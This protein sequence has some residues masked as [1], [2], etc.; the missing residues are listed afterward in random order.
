M[1]RLSLRAILCKKIYAMDK[2]CMC[3]IKFSFKRLQKLFSAIGTAFFAGLLI[4]A[5]F[6]TS[7]VAETASKSGSIIY[8]N[9]AVSGGAGDGGSWADAYGS[10]QDALGVATSGDEI[11]VAAGVYY[12]DDGVAQT[13]ND[14][15][16]TFQ[17][18]DGIKVYGGFDATE[19]LLSERDWE[20]NLTVLSGDIDQNDTTNGYGLVTDPDS[21]SGTNSMHVVNTSNVTNTTTIDGFAI[22]AGSA[23]R[24]SGPT[25]VNQG[26]GL[27]SDDGHPQLA[28]MLFVGNQ[29]WEQGGAAYVSGS[30]SSW[31]D[32][33]LTNVSFIN[34]RVKAD[35]VDEGEVRAPQNTEYDG[36]AIYVYGTNLT[37]IDVDFLFNKVNGETQHADY[38]NSGAMHFRSGRLTMHGARVI[39]NQAEANYGGV[40]IRIYNNENFADI[41]N[42]VFAG[43]TSGQRGAA[44]AIYTNNGPVTLTNNTFVGNWSKETEV[45]LELTGSVISTTDYTVENNILWDNFSGTGPISETANVSVASNLTT[46]FSNNLIGGSMGSGASWNVPYA[47]DGGGNLDVDP[48]FILPIT[49]TSVPTEAGAFLLEPTSPAIGVAKSSSCPAEDILGTS[50]LADSVCDMGAYEYK[51]QHDWAINSTA[52]GSDAILGDGLC[53]S[54]LMMLGEQ[55]TLRAAIDEANAIPNRS[56]LTLPAGTFTIALEG[57]Q[58]DS[59]ATGDYDIWDDL[60]LAGAGQDATFIQAG[61]DADSGLDRVFHVMT[62]T[63]SLDLSDL[64][65]RYGRIVSTVTTTGSEDGSGLFNVTDAT[66]TITSTTFAENSI[67]KVD[68]DGGAIG[69]IGGGTVR[70]TDSM[71]LNNRAEGGTG[72]SG[73]GLFNAFGSHII[74]HNSVISGNVASSKGGGIYSNR[75]GATILVSNSTIANNHAGILGGGVQNGA[76]LVMTNTTVSG[77]SSDDNGGGISNDSMD[78]NFTGSHLTIVNNSADSSGGGLWLEQLAQVTLK[79][80]IVANSV[81]GGDCAETDG[82]FSDGGYNLV[83]DGSC[84]SAGTSFD[85][86]P[87]LGG[88]ADNGGDTPT[89]LPEQSSPALNTIPSGVNG[90]GTTFQTDQRGA[91]RPLESS[92]DMGAVETD[93]LSPASLN[94]SLSS[95][96]DNATNVEPGSPVLYTILITNSG[97]ATADGAVLYDLIPAEIISVTYTD[98]S[99]QGVTLTL[100]AGT[101]AVWTLDGLA[102]NGTAAMLIQGTVDPA[103]Y[104]ATISNTARLSFNG[105][106]LSQTVVFTTQADTTEPVFPPAPL[107][108]PPDG[109]TVGDDRLTFNW[110]DAFDT[111][112]GIVSYT[113]LVTGTLPAESV[114][115]IAADTIVT[116][117]FVTTETSFTPPSSLP[118]GNYE[119]T[120]QA[121]DGVGNITRA[122]ESFTFELVAEHTVYLPII[123]R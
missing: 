114:S 108:Q 86:D 118:A 96:L 58:E 5:T 22:T 36:G 83:E 103:A 119:W 107:N 65:V 60:S 16:A 26:G 113:V 33:S 110:D 34:N 10:L 84:I 120:V 37:L 66:V 47:I 56:D 18:T 90:C 73:G 99:D 57:F 35:I 27:Y 112:S 20:T 41:Q 39:G 64:T 116:Y 48:E 12:P 46:T 72:S 97:E 54:D 123:R 31:I 63:Q 55:C 67:E 25:S 40:E 15:D 45:A 9:H 43:N 28:N 49:T 53:D 78:S 38:L 76:T 21:I 61:S 50:R 111:Q 104:S 115:N 42:V 70:L 101:S 51:A 77:N 87:S 69:N 100:Q 14:V 82:S 17:L 62:G 1:G 88:L 79:N 44:L 68:E 105:S 71:I 59:N 30:Y 19:T 23:A 2:G 85:G 29:A 13:D 81:A 93:G 24:S 11:W 8:V 122:Q 89:H 7:A 4:Y 121:H 75:D 102:S 106:D 95:N 94:L 3:S 92:C 74:V 98:Q 109:G 32:A 80:S 6:S 52:D 117:T 91:I